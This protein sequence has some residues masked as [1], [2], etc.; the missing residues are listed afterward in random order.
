MNAKSIN[1]D[2]LKIIYPVSLRGSLLINRNS[3]LFMTTALIITDAASL[4]SAGLAAFGL[5]YALGNLVNP[6]FYWNLIPLIPLF[7]ALFAL[8]GL[9]P[10]VGLSPVEELRR[11]TTSTSAAFMLL[12]AFTFWARSAELFSRLIFAFAWIFALLLVPLFRW[13]LRSFLISR[14]SWGEPAAIVGCSDQAQTV[15]NYLLSHPRLGL[16]PVVYLDCM[17]T[18]CS[19]ELGL[20]IFRFGEMINLDTLLHQA[21]IRTAILSEGGLPKELQNAIVNEQYF[22]FDRLILVSDLKW[23]GSLGVTPYDFEGF[24]GLEI[25]QNLLNPW[26]Q[27]TKRI[28]DLILGFLCSLLLAPLMLLIAILIRIDSPGRVIFRHLRVGKGGKPLMVWKFRTMIVDGD[29]VLQEHFERN[30]EARREWI[31]NQKIRNDPRITRIG[32]FLRRYSLDEL[33]QIWNVFKG[34][35]SLVGP[36]P[37]VTREIDL[38]QQGFTL[39]KHV[40]PGITGLWQVSGRNDLSYAERVQLDEYYVRN[41]SIWL[42][43]YILI[44]TIG[45]VLKRTGAY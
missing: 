7:L 39:Y 33:P 10:A 36:R 30:P 40:L 34:E 6:P 17:D 11:L 18:S 32:R 24:L 37:I 23:I 2:F 15:S 20:P 14:L 16:R 35:M 9:Y 44:C 31:E 19:R 29:R 45:V 4:F 38:Y 12:T 3:R 21:G 26:E 43:L 28:L 41:W 1:P 22:H 8:R 13:S 25:R 42:D 27:R 5:R